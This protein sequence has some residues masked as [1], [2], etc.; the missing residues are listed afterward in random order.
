MFKLLAAIFMFIDHFGHIFNQHIPYELYLVLR[1]IGRLAFPMYAYAIAKGF[2][3]TS[4]INKYISRMFIMSIVTQSLFYLV[5]NSFNQE[6]FYF[7][8]V[9][10]TFTMALLFMSGFEDISHDDTTRA[11]IGSFKL[12]TSFFITVFLEPDYGVIG[13]IIVVIFQGL[14]KYYSDSNKVYLYYFLTLFGLNLMNII[15]QDLSSLTYYS[16]ISFWQILAVAFFPFESK[17]KK[18]GNISKIANY[19]FYPIH[20][21]VLLMFEAWWI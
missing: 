6:D 8:N 5:T 15:G 1:S 16:F 4:N 10:I 20:Y 9:L 2:N 17:E 11:I 12:I 7:Y 13:L 18:P 3:R 21:V 19:W 14:D